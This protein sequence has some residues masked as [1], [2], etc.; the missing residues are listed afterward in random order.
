MK[1]PSHGVRNWVNLSPMSA[2]VGWSTATAGEQGRAVHPHERAGLGVHAG[3]VAR[4]G[5][6]VEKA[7]RPEAELPV[8]TS[9]R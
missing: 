4:H 5:V 7:A 8:S 2:V 3:A 9:S 6:D 1:T